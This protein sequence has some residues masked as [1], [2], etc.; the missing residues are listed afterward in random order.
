VA[1]SGLRRY[2]ES[3]CEAA[4]SALAGRMA[5]ADLD[6]DRRCAHPEANLVFTVPPG[7]WPVIASQLGGGM[8]GE[9]SADGR[10]RPKFCSVYSSSALAVNTFGPFDES[11]TLPIPGAGA[12]RGG[13]EFEAQRT[14]GVRGFK[15]NLDLVTEPDNA[16]WL[17]AESKCLEYLRPH[18]TAFSDAFVAKADKLLTIETAR[19]YARFAKVKK[20]GR[21][22]YELVD[23][24]QLL[25]HF[26]AAKVAGAD[27]R[28]VT[29]AYLFWEPADAPEHEVFAVHRHE[30][31]QLAAALVDD[32]VRLKPLS[33]RDLWSHWDHQPFLAEHVAA[34]RARYDVRLG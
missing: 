22:L 20:D 16:D 17:Y 32:H 26:L 28:R 7:R 12:Y 27:R 19:Y 14:A 5:S 13:I 10:R 15:P 21:H 9:L 18:G 33:Y 11:R 24:A 8:G 1:T 4:K 23:A 6:G 31:D 30:A 2:A 3:A 29:L 34:L 25:K